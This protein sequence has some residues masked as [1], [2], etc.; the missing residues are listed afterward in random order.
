[1]IPSRTWFTRDRLSPGDIETL[2][3]LFE[4]GTRQVDLASKFGI[5]VSSVKRILRVRR[6]QK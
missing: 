6:A 4:A 2:V 5:S 3:E 1:M